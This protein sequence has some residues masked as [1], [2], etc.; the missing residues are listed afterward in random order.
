MAAVYVTDDKIFCVYMADDPEA[1]REHA[2]AGGFPADAVHR[3][4]TIIDPSTGGR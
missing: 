1:L 4:G 3:V 2:D